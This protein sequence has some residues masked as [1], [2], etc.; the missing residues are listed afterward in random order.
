M[1]STPINTKGFEELLKLIENTSKDS[2]DLYEGLFRFN[3]H[4][5][6]QLDGLTNALAEIRDTL[7]RSYELHRSM[8]NLASVSVGEDGKTDVVDEY[9]FN[10]HVIAMNPSKTAS[11]TDLAIELKRKGK[12]VIKLC[13]GE[14]HF[15]IPAPKVALDGAHHALDS[16]NTRYTSGTGT[17]ELRVKVCEKLARDNGLKYEPNQIV[18]SNGAKQTVSQVVLAF[19]SPGA[20]VI[21]PSPCWV[22]YPDM[23]TMYGAKPVV[24]PSL[25]ENDYLLTPSELEAAIT[26]NTRL[27]ILVSPCNPTVRVAFLDECVCHSFLLFFFYLFLAVSFSPF[28]VRIFYSVFYVHSKA[29]LNTIFSCSLWFS[30]PLTFLSQGSVYSREQLEGLAA[31]LKRHPKVTVVCDEIYEYLLYDDAKHISLASLPGMY[32]RVIVV[33]GVSKGYAMTGFRIGYAAAPLRIA[34]VLGK[35]QSQTTGS[36]SSI[37]QEAA[38]AVLSLDSKSAPVVEAMAKYKALRDIVVQELKQMPGVSFVLP[39]GAF[40]IL[41]DVSVCFGKQTASG[42]VVNNA[43]DFCRILLSEFGVAIAPGDA[44]YAPGTVRI[45]FCTDPELLRKGMGRI[46]EFATSLSP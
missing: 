1:E 12:E 14:P 29:I 11:I 37:S 16:G 42:E 31:V 46:R 33:N 23:C 4:S 27:L 17:F 22:S 7:H 39:R 20:E 21:I 38:E 28:Q 25:A 45:A 10:P 13:V 32:S 35:I 36:P 43:E 5:K 6:S 34:K 26:P 9:D 2:F 41:P 19:A 15:D 3:P 44:F 30:P 18:V 8:E 24:V 40:Y